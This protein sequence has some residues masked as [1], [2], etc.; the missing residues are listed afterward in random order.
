MASTDVSVATTRK[1]AKAVPVAI[2]DTEALIDAITRA[3]RDPKVDIAKMDWLLQTSLTLKD[4]QARVDYNDA[5]AR[6]QAALEPVRK[7]ASNPQTSSKYATDAKLDEAIREY[8]IAEGFTLSFDTEPMDRENTLLV[9]CYVSRGRERRRHQIPM[10]CDGL[11]PKGAPVMTRTHATGS[12]FTYGKRYL[13]AGIFNVITADMV[14]DDGNRASYRSSP[15]QYQQAV[16]EAPPPP[17]DDER[18]EHTRKAVE[19]IKKPSLAETQLKASVALITKKE[20][21]EL[22]KLMGEAG[23]AEE[24]ERIIKDHYEIPTLDMLTHAQ[25]EIACNK[26][27]SLIQGAKKNAK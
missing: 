14:D 25:F 8:Y 2:N 21:A 1:R 17:A 27:R 12:A 11:G 10:P 24:R 22:Y 26:L 3:S 16:D 23:K 6:V 18:A 13:R 4:D 9:V 19:N 15:S 7:Q 5:M 20:L